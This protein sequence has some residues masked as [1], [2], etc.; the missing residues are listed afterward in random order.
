MH[1]WQDKYSFK[2]K[3]DQNNNYSI[4][5]SGEDFDNEEEYFFL[6][7]GS[8]LYS[9]VE[10]MKKDIIHNALKF[11]SKFSTLQDLYNFQIMPILDGNKDLPN[12]GAD[13]VFEYLKLCNIVSPENYELLKKYILNQ[14]EVMNNRGEPN[15]I[16]YYP[17]LN[18]ILQEIETKG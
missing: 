7:D 1:I 16:E 15:I 13:W 3:T 17:I 12:V 18:N 2:S 5:L 9:T 4:I 10:I 14:V 11:A 6:I 8:D